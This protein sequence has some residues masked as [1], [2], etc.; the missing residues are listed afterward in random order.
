MAEKIGYSLLWDD[1]TGDI[2]LI[3]GKPV[4]AADELSVLEWLNCNLGVE[5]DAFDIYEGTDIGIP[6]RELIGAKGAV[7]AGT[8]MAVLEGSVEET[9]LA[10][11]AVERVNDIRLTQSG[12]TVTLGL[13]AESVYGDV[14]EVTAYEFN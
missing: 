13:S 1:D 8:I 12:T 9:A 14:E 11:I 7:P 3:D 10:C 2:T 6:L 4:L 5:K